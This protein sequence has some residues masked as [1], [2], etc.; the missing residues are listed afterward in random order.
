M[1]KLHQKESIRILKFAHKLV[2]L[3]ISSGGENLKDGVYTWKQ[4]GINK[5]NNDGKSGNIQP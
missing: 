2:D 5:N 3:L 4:M 1:K